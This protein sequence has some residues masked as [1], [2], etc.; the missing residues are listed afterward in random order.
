[1]G[2]VQ[3]K[4]LLILPYLSTQ[5]P[6]L[7]RLEVPSYFSSF[8]FQTQPLNT[9]TNS[10]F[11]LR[12]RLSHWS[13]PLFFFFFF[14]FFFPILL[15]PQRCNPGLNQ[16]RL[17]PRKNVFLTCYACFHFLLVSL[18]HGQNPTTQLWFTHMEANWVDKQYMA[19]SMNIAKGRRRIQ[20]A[21]RAGLHCTVQYWPSI[22]KLCRETMQ[23]HGGMTMAMR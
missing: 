18:F 22:F 15:R 21:Y 4:Q 3:V 14:V 6:R 13:P 23:Q 9:F 16:I 8:A 10:Q 1:M 2:Q 7:G 19:V 17:P 11:T 5:L 12:S 20:I